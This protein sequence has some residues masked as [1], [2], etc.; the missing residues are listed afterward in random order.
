MNVADFKTKTEFIETKNVIKTSKS[1]P[2]AL[3]IGYSAV[4][5][6]SSIARFRFPSF[7]RPSTGPEL[8]SGANDED[9]IEY[10]N[11]S[12]EVWKVGEAAYQALSQGD[13]EDDEKSLYN[14][15]RYGNPMFLV[16]ARVGLA[17]ACSNKKGHF[18]AHGKSIVL[19]TG[20]PPKYLDADTPILKNKLAGTHKFQIRVGNGPWQDFNITLKKENI[21]VMTQPSGSLFGVAF[22]NNATPIADI[23]KLFSSK[24]IIFDAGFGTLDVFTVKNNTPDATNTFDNLGMKAVFLDVLGGFK[25]KYNQEI[26]IHYFQNCLK[27]EYIAITERVKLI[28]KKVKFAKPLESSSK[29]ICD[30]A[31]DKIAEI[32]DLTDW[33]YFIVTGGTG[34]C[35]YEQI[36]KH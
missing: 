19:Q 1:W 16:I 6:Y 29:K 9:C 22:K 15:Y 21:H 18:A 33:S 20:L 31:I 34:E 25:R 35:W 2:I 5:G 32:Y 17:L 3:D 36:K 11:E 8:L 26:P 13:L 10:K 12:G 4:K 30:A 24:V 28:S 7:A 14:R 27:N 23:N